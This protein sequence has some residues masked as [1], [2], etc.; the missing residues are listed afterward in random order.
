MARLW[1]GREAVGSVFGGA[2]EDKI[3]RSLCSK[4]S[5][6]DFIYPEDNRNLESVSYITTGT[7]SKKVLKL[8]I[9]SG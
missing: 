7:P 4:L 9:L 2:S 3:S 6:L 5:I 8:N 1:T